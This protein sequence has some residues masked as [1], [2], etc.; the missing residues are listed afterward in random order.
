MVDIS[1]SKTGKHGHA[2]A[3]IVA[4][5]IFT[6]NKYQDVCPTSHNMEAPFVKAQEYQLLDITPENFVTLMLPESGDTREDL[7]MPPDAELAQ[8]IRDT[9]EGGETVMVMVQ[10]AMGHEQIMSFKVSRD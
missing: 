4:L 6:N 9:F 8:R 2:K 5:D 1:T 7:K 10:T 3:N